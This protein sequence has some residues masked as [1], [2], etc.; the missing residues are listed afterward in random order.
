LIDHQAILDEEIEV[1]ESIFPD[2]LESELTSPLSLKPDS[3]LGQRSHLGKYK[4]RSKLKDPQVDLVS[5]RSR[6]LTQC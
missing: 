2:E 6:F 3:Q 5:V 4:S 1:L